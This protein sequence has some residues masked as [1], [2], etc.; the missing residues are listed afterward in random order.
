[1]KKKMGD[2]RR[3]MGD[4]RWE[5]GGGFNKLILNPSTV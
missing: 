4:G 3:E 2:G 1:V 5:F